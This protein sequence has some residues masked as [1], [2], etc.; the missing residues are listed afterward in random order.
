MKQRQT[1]LKIVDSKPVRRIL[2]PDAGYGLH[3][4]AILFF[5]SFSASLRIVETAFAVSVPAMGTVRSRN[6]FFLRFLMSKKGAPSIHHGA[7]ADV[8]KL[9]ICTLDSIDWSD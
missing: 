4:H 2:C 9:F 8:I 7:A 5:L 6:Q 3:Y 1:G